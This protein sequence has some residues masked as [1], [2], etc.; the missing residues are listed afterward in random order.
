MKKVIIFLTFVSLLIS[1]STTKNDSQTTLAL[2]AYGDNDGTTAVYAVGKGPFIPLEEVKENIVFE[3]DEMENT[4]PSEALDDI[5][6][7]NAENYCLVNIDNSLT[8]PRHIGDN[9][10]HISVYDSSSPSKFVDAKCI[11]ET[12]HVYY[13]LDNRYSVDLAEIKE[14]AALFEPEYDE[15]R[16]FFGKEA[17]VDNNGKII[18]LITDI[19]EMGYYYMLDQYSKEGLL[20]SGIEYESNESDMLYINIDI[21][22]PNSDYTFDDAIAT[23]CHEFSHMTYFNERYKNNLEEEDMTFISEG[24]A[25]W[26]EY[27]V[28]Y[29]AHHSENYI[30]PFIYDSE[31]TDIFCED[32]SIYGYGLLFFRYFE[33]RFGLDAIKKLVSSEYVGLQALEDAAGYSFDLIFDDF[34]QSLLA[35]AACL[36]DNEYY[37][38]NLNDIENGFCLSLDV[39]SAFLEEGRDYLIGFDICENV[40]GALYPYTICFILSEVDDIDFESNGALMYYSCL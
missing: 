14:L 17:D 9:W 36:V 40:Y 24:L 21:F 28:G 10:D 5:E 22:D 18:F 11:L 6:E 15:I 29:P 25:M 2:V 38:E 33:E 34:A 8:T 35:T 26:T 1:C 4:S 23:I 16:S 37:L 32:N 39:I 7:Y 13:Y 27:Y 19:D 30:V 12:E 3:V 20:N 31:E